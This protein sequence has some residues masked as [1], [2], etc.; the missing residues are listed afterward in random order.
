VTLWIRTDGSRSVGLGHIK[1]CLTI[2]DEARRRGLSVN[3]VVSTG[4]DI[5][6]PILI[7][8]NFPVVQVPS[9]SHDWLTELRAGDFLLLD[10]YH[11]GDQ[12][13]AAVQTPGIRVATFDDLDVDLPPVD[14]LLMP[15]L[16]ESTIRRSIR[17]RVLTG[18]RFAPVASQFTSM[19]RLRW[20]RV[21][22]LLVTLGSS[23]PSNL[24]VP[25]LRAIATLQ[26]SWNV[27]LLVGPG[28][29][30]V[31]PPAYPQFS[32]IRLSGE[33]SPFFDRFDAAISAA[34][35]TT[36]E[37]LC[38]GMPT[39]LVVAAENQRGVVHTAISNSAALYGGDAETIE[40]D[41]PGALLDLADPDCRRK[42]S[43]SALKLID[44][45]GAERIVEAFLN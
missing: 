21:G 37:L 45:K 41:L 44:G 4:N 15:S 39:A 20:E 7:A 11:L 42:L 43:S 16:M 19:R 8:A 22:S 38:M 34:G 10:G 2:A 23:D 29:K 17:S 5:G 14:L 27:T 13:E 25:V 26:V 9:F 24:A 35:T 3:F 32:A 33:L 6:L 40:T 12:I 18:P 31:I 30:D 36:W 1:R 28:M